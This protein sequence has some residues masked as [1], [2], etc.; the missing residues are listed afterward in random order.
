MKF[1]FSKK[2]KI[3]ILED[4][5]TGIVV[6]A[7]LIYGFGKLFQ[8]SGAIEI[9]KTVAEMTGMEI[10]WAFYGYSKPFAITIGILEV[11]GGL[12]LL[13]KKTRLIGCLFVSTILT[14]IILQD[15]FYGVHVGALKAAILYQVLIFIILWM[16]RLRV[17]EIFYLFIKPN[18]SALKNG[19]YFIKIVIAFLLF[20]IFRIV[21]YFITMP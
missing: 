8:F 10:M 9:D 7:M 17:I 1:N 16:N 15:I 19:H 2:D 13:L 6:F 18:S 14:N 20:L 4:A 11:L 3:E 12:I 21:E 5:L